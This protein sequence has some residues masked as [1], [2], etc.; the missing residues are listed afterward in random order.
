MTR[1][2][3]RIAAA[4]ALVILTGVASR[5]SGLPLPRLIAKDLGDVL[6]SV[7]FY[8]LVLLARPRT[9]VPAAALTALAIAAATEFLKLYHA[10]WIDALRTHRVP[11]FL[12]GHRFL[13]TNLAAYAA[14]VV[15][16]VILD[17]PLLHPH[18]PPPTSNS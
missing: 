18:R 4:L 3:T 14:G 5:V 12:L 11:S 13:W 10:P 15:A 17:R 7:M 16:A 1:A 6:W 9:P 8:L 2:R